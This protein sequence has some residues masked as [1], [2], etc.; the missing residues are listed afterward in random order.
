MLYQLSYTRLHSLLLPPNHG[1]DERIRTSDP[2][3]PKQVRY[4]AA[5]RPDSRTPLASAAR[6]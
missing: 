5:P 1:R 4:Q 6:V 3:L 2:L